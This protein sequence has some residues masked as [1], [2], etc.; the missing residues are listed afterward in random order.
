MFKSSGV[1]ACSTRNPVIRP[2]LPPDFGLKTGQENRGNSATYQTWKGFARR[3]SHGLWRYGVEPLA[4]NVDNTT[5]NRKLNGTIELLGKQRQ[6]LHREPFLFVGLA[7]KFI[8]AEEVDL[9]G[10][11]LF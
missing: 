10:I 2:I 11:G 3:T 4:R 1:F 9:Y 7:L 6:I 8:H 5:Q